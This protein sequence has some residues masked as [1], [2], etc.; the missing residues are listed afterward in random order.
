MTLS[1]LQVL[2]NIMAFEV[3]GLTYLDLAISSSDK[4]T[5]REL[6]L[7][8]KGLSEENKNDI[9]FILVEKDYKENII[10]LYK[11]KFYKDASTIVANLSSV[12]VK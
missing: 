10:L 8:L 1:Y 11:K 4:H 2:A 12:M 3:E 5:P 7:E 9:I 6:I